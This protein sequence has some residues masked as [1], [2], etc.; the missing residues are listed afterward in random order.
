MTKKN[1]L[2][3]YLIKQEF[4][5]FGDIIKYCENDKTLDDN[6]SVY[7]GYSKN[8]KPHWATNFLKD[9][10]DTGSLFV[11]NARAV[12]LKR[13]NIENE[14][15]R[16]FAIVM[17]YGKNMLNDD[18]I[19]E[20][21]GLK[22]ALNSIKHDSLRRINK[23]NIGGNQKLSYEQ[24]PLKS[25]INDFGLDIN[26]DLVSHITGETNTFVKGTIS[27]SDALFCS[28]EVDIGNI[29]EFLI[30]VYK[31]YK[32]DKYKENFAWIDQIQ[33]IKSSRE[34]EKLNNFL[35][36]SIN[37]NSN[38]FWMAAPELVDWENIRGYKY[39]GKKIFDDI[40]INEVK[41][42]L[43]KPLTSIEQ[44]KSKKI[45]VISSLDD[46]KSMTWNSLKCIYGECSIDGQAYCINAGKWYYMDKSFVEDINAE[47]EST[48]ISQIDFQ[49]RTSKHDSEGQYTIDF[50]NNNH[51]KFLAMD[52]KNIM[53]GGGHS[54]IELCDLISSSQELIHLKPYSGSSTLSHLFNQ[55]VVS[56]EL[57]IADEDF[58]KKANDKIV[59]QRSGGEFQ[60]SDAKKVKIVF[61]IISKD[62]N[63]LPKIPFFSKVAFK[64]AKSRLRAFGLDVSI[65]NIYDA[66]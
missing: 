15:F 4:Q 54:S 52:K 10:V 35:I 16:I 38:L 59:E 42:S 53:H 36:E 17:G 23:T 64:Y 21:F 25:K 3:V 12:V 31:Q 50:A 41:E 49:E 27:G 30:K 40:D 18:V 32:S 11:A 6:T 29:G 13:V 56:A 45:V 60:I 34:K 7:L 8:T 44:L 5:N 19:E 39:H 61:G 62:M 46:S 2:A 58:L 57:L 1:K 33:D 47:Y 43:S 63:S 24:L 22:V 55:G 65:K 14:Q 20:R 9:F 37:N 48:I 26:R 28:A 66:R 51:S